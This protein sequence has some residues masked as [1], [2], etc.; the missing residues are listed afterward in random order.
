MDDFP[1]VIIMRRL[2]EYSAI[3]F[4]CC[5][6]GAAWAGGLMIRSGSVAY[7]EGDQIVEPR[8]RV[9]VRFLA[10]EYIYGARQFAYTAWA[11]IPESAAM[12][13]KPQELA[14]WDLYGVVSS[15]PNREVS[16]RDAASPYVLSFNA[17]EK[18]G[19][20]KLVIGS[21]PIFRDSPLKS[22]NVGYKQVFIPHTS[23]RE[24]LATAI[25]N[26]PGSATLVARFTVSATQVA[27]DQSPRLYLKMNG[28][29][30]YT[31]STPGGLQK[32]PLVFSWS[33]GPEFVKDVKK[34][35]YRYR[36][37]PEDD[38]WG[39]WTTQRDVEYSFLLKGVHQFSVQARYLDER[40]KLESQ[41]A[42]FQFNLPKDHVSKPTPASLIKGPY[43]AQLP[44]ERPIAFSEV[45][46]KSRALLIGM[47]KFDDV[48][49]FPQ[50]EEARIA[51]DI[52]AMESALKKNG[53]E[54]TTLRKE[55]VS[56]E[57]V[58]EAISTIVDAAG[59]DDRI[60]VYFSTHGFPDPGKPA[61]GYLATSD[62]QYQR[63]A[64]RCVRLD[65]LEVHSR[66]ALESKLAK[67]V[68]FAVDSCFAGLGIVR[69]SVG[70][71]DLSRLAVPQGSFMLTAGMA[72]QLAQIDPG[73]GMSTFTYYLAEGL[74][75]AADILGNNGLITLSE[76][77]VYV[78]Y[79]VAEKTQA[80]QI[81]M[82][83]RIRGDGE[84]LFKP[85]PGN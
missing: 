23:D 12:S 28:K 76:L 60:L 80:Q 7:V 39:A 74:N 70:V 19:K 50:F 42:M 72:N 24:V 61:D 45:Y 25:S 56:R 78:Q 57:D 81:P 15:T 26:Y 85:T 33:V 21:V 48:M 37:E 62:C 8:A 41:P 3:A 11:V 75:G 55:R 73:L 18:A 68:L 69:K 77:Y 46:A 36:L 1:E 71:A 16:L 82:L 65:D 38:D 54:V 27:R 52:T 40:T 35:M 66:M 10:D 47:W 2:R 53:F 4:L 20:Y 51:A 84:M 29:V 17:P 44:S 5:L 79:K 31:V 6:A 14:K 59:R 58:I 9:A 63:P 49:H 32:D 22:G 13:P 67:Q 83:G 30:P 64:V 43:G 34:V